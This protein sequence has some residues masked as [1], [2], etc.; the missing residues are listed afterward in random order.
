MKKLKKTSIKKTNNI[1]SV[2]HSINY[3]ECWKCKGTG[4]LDPEHD[5]FN[6]YEN[7]NNNFCYECD[8]TGFYE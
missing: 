8:G 6:D 1:E 3:N 4:F 2:D 5:M 7:S